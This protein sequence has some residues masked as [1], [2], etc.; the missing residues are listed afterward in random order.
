MYFVSISDMTTT[1]KMYLFLPQLHA[2]L[3]KN[4]IYEG[5]IKVEC[6]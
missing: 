6:Y 2:I 5:I 1:D 4:L 3:V